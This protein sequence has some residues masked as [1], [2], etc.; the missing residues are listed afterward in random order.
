MTEDIL[1]YNFNRAAFYCNDNGEF[2]MVRI[3]NPNLSDKTGDYP[4]ISASEAETLLLNGNY[5]TTVPYEIAGKEYISKTE[6]VYRTG[7][8]EKYYMP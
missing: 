7:T 5:I 8:Y 3:F 1:N 4:V 6:L 2:Y